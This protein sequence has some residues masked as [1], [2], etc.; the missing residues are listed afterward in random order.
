MKI[1]EE[2]ITHVADL[3][4]LELSPGEVGSMTV[5]LDRILS[6]VEKLNQLDTAGVAPTT[7]ALSIQNAFR[8]D[9]VRPSLDRKD[10][11]ANAPA[12]NGEAFVVPRVI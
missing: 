8:P 5:Q 4:R 11:L 9:Q 12:E 1:T 3:A 10:S 7:H 6:Y 2:Q